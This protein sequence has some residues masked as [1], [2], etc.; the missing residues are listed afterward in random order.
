MWSNTNCPLPM[1]PMVYPESLIRFPLKPLN[2][3]KPISS[4]STVFR[5][6]IFTFRGRSTGADVTDAQPGPEREMGPPWT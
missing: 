3:R 6:S 2:E 4:K 1:A 5:L